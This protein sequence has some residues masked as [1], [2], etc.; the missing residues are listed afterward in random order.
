M[1][2]LWVVLTVQNL[3]FSLQW[4][5]APK[6]NPVHHDALYLQH[7]TV[8]QRKNVSNPIIQFFEFDYFK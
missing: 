5:K 8:K 2:H 1:V 7:L 4:R 3:Y 6:L